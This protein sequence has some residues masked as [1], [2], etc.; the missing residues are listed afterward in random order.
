MIRENSF[1]HD[2][3]RS[4]AILHDDGHEDEEE[5][6]KRFLPKLFCKH[7]PTEHEGC[8]LK[9]YDET[10]GINTTQGEGK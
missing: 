10:E 9:H 6:E 1:S 7:E 8:T 3:S 2:F 4:S 5:R